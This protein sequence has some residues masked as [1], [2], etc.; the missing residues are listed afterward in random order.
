MSYELKI[1]FHSH[2]NY[3][4]KIY[5][6]VIGCESDSRLS[7]EVRIKSSGAEYCI[8]GS[9]FSI[10]WLKV[11]QPNGSNLNAW[12]IH[13]SVHFSR[14]NFNTSFISNL[15]LLGYGHG[16]V[17]FLLSVNVLSIFMEGV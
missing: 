1:N 4:K 15:H 10:Q 9:G 6:K 5:G 8:T 17:S 2:K 3:Q 14:F 16:V 12:I 13:C 7:Y 11:S